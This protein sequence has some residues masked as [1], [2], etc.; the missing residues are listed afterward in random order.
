MNTIQVVAFYKNSK[1]P[2]RIYNAYVNASGTEI[3]HGD[4]TYLLKSGRIKE[5]R[6]WI[7]GKIEGLEI[8]NYDHKESFDKRYLFRTFK[9][10]ETNGVQVYFFKH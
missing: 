3:T 2:S 4:D 1:K 9:A 10:S 8:L 6:N 5:K 7:H